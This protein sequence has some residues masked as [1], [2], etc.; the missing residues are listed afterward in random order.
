[1][2]IQARLSPGRQCWPVYRGSREF[3]GRPAPGSQPGCGR[4]AGLLRNT[5][6]G[7]GTSVPGS[8]YSGAWQT[9]PA[10]PFLSGQRQASEGS[11][12]RVPWRTAPSKA[13]QKKVFTWHADGAAGGKGRP[14][15]ARGAPPPPMPLAGTL[16]KTRQIPA[17]LGKV[18]I[19][20]AASAVC[21]SWGSSRMPGVRR[22]LQ[23]F[24]EP[25]YPLAGALAGTSGITRK[26]HPHATPWRAVVRSGEDLPGI[27]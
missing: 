16:G 24:Q 4:G 2:P 14:S 23:E 22:L 6:E 8:P 17:K 20:V 11:W 10:R 19:L 3:A 7:L 15:A 9:S 12:R 1:M 21:L 25:S 18:I 13:G 5:A 26:V 27:P